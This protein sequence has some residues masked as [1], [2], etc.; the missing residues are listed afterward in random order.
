MHPLILPLAHIQDAGWYV[1]ILMTPF[2]LY[3]AW[4]EVKRRNER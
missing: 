2:F 4:Q 1:L 3:L